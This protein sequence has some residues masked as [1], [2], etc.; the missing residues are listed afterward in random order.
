MNKKAL[1]TGI[2]GQDGSYL[3]EHLLNQGYSVYGMLKRN[4]IAETQDLR[5]QHLEN[6]I[7]TMYGDMTDFSSLANIIRKIKPGF[8]FNL[9]AQSH[10]RI[11]IDM[12][13][14]TAQV[15][16]IGVLNVLEALRIF[17]PRARFYQAS[18]SEMFGN[19]IDKDHVQRLTTPMKPVSPYGIAKVYA[20]NMTRHY[21][22]GHHMFCSNGILFNHE[23][24]RRGSN[25][26]TAKVV[27]TAVEIKLGLKNKLVL[28]NLDTKRDWG[29]SKDYT[30][31]MILILNHSSPDD[32]IVAS[33]E[34]HSIRELCQYV[35][36]KLDMDY[37]KYV[38]QN[39]KYM[40]PEELNELKGDASKA[41][42]ILKWAPEY[43]YEDLLD[44]MIDYWM[45]K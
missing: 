3:A 44:E 41:K 18:S 45:R 38:E 28:G 29:H 22:N 10:V 11:S 31:A 9:A 21:R 4:S 27:K 16:A 1:I 35:F 39:P 37:L 25:F 40:R 34:N 13:I 30:R 7:E 14:Y 23:S 8:V 15:N 26:V 24:P 12:P 33:G 32:F 6:D 43:S 17:A 42:K 20:F 5:I 36:A 19:S 2:N